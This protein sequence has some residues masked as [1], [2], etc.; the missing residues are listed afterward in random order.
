MR[1][2][3]FVF[4]KFGNK[5]QKS[6][7][8][9]ATGKT[10][11]ANFAF[12]N[13]LINVRFSSFGVCSLPSAICFFLFVFWYMPS[14]Y[15]KSYLKKIDP[16]VVVSDSVCQYSIN[17][18]NGGL[19]ASC[20]ICPANAS[21][22]IIWYDAALNPVATGSPFDP[23]KLKLVNSAIPGNYTFTAVCKCLPNASNDPNLISDGAQVTFKVIGLPVPKIL[24]NALPCS[25]EIAIYV[26]TDSSAN[27]YV[28]KYSWSLSGGGVLSQNNGSATVKW[29]SGGNSGPYTL[30]VREKN[31][32]GCESATDYIVYI[33]GVVLS[34]LPK[35]NISLNSNCQTDVYVQ[36]V[37][38]RIVNGAS[39]MQLQL[40]WA[41]NAPVL[42]SGIGKI[43]IDGISPQVG[44]YDYKSNTFVYTVTENCTGNSCSGNI[45]VADNTPPAVTAPNDFTVNCSDSLNLIMNTEKIKVVTDI[46]LLN[47]PYSLYITDCSAYKISYSDAYYD[48]SCLTPFT[49]FP[50][51]IILTRTSRPKTLPN[52]DIT[53]I[54]V[55][56]FMVRDI[57]ANVSTAQQIIYVRKALLRNVVLPTDIEIDYK[58]AINHISSGVPILVDSLNGQ[59]TNSYQLTAASGLN[60]IY[61]D[62]SI[63]RCGKSFTILRHWKILDGC[64]V[65]DPTASVDARFKNGSQII[66]VIDR[67]PPNT[68]AQF[69]QYYVFNG[70]LSV[71]DTT[72]NFVDT[73]Q[74]LNTN[75]VY[76][77]GLSSSCGASVRFT[78][79]C[80]KL[81]TLNAQPITFRVSD[82]RLQV[83]KGYPAVDSSTGETVAIFEGI[84]DA[85]GDYNITFYVADACGYA[86]AKKTFIIHVRD[87]VK[88]QVVCASNI[89]VSL[90]SNKMAIITSDQLNVGSTDNC[91]IQKILVRRISNCQNP[92][93]VEFKDNVSF[94]CCDV[95][96]TILVIMRVYDYFGN[97]ND[98]SVS[99]VVQDNLN[100]CPPVVSTLNG[101]IQ[102]ENGVAIEGV[103]V[104][105]VSNGI[106]LG[107][108]LTTSTGNF[109]INN[110]N[111]SQKVSTYATRNDDA[112][113]GVTTYDI[114]LISR[115]ILD[116][117]PLPTTYKM[118]AADVNKDGE[119][120]ALDM[121]LM[122]RLVLHIIPNFPNNTAWR[123]I[124][125]NYTFAHPTDPFSENFPEVIA[126]NIFKGTNIA[127]F[128]GVKIG[129]LNNSV[130]ANNDLNALVTRGVNSNF[131]LKITTPDKNLKAGETIDIVLHTDN[132][133][134][135]GF[136]FTL[137]TIKDLE[138]R[139]VSKAGYSSKDFDI[140]DTN[141]GLFENALTVSWN[142]KQ[143]NSATDIITVTVRAKNNMHLSEALSIGSNITPIEAFDV[144][145]KI[146]KVVL[147]ILKDNSTPN[148]A[149]NYFKLYQNA[150][151]PF[152]SETNIGFDLSDDTPIKL[153][154]T[155]A[156][157]QVIKVFEKKGVRGY[158]TINLNKSDIGTAGLYFYRLEAGMKSET[159]MTVID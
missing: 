157:G 132:L 47:S 55:R 22:S 92:T 68:T 13:S 3:S 8:K 79:R 115:H 75:N 143:T 151:N 25:N 110:L 27:A 89:K 96:E 41:Y 46:S 19:K 88:P 56:T 74:G 113:N 73:L 127:N 16:P 35:I 40:F 24:G 53:R 14:A 146:G 150:P 123:F 49:I 2:P 120:N 23:I 64:A 76:P 37:L 135:Q 48:I 69:T 122:R 126:T 153:T 66:K 30:T 105:T 103:S 5:V 158:N 125:K 109:T 81:S 1:L 141:F 21:P 93:D 107:T 147:A 131:E 39:Q 15:C 133:T 108:F 116:I 34:C 33:K 98:C 20:A 121:L 102:T 138:I 145:G 50:D 71:R 84:F 67:L 29:N 63:S 114:A 112:Q 7:I 140:S 85:Y 94:F 42:E 54:I 72:S 83:L 99:V 156:Q 111:V 4:T 136:Q 10:Q 155:N 134:A 44:A 17:S 62:D 101:S 95:N 128:V 26:C 65:Y 61:S 77:Q 52:P 100:L 36:D 18:F 58:D 80:P 90:T 148:T 31:I 149:H 104:N 6:R 60:V 139:A 38:A 82:S 159:L 9:N 144:D 117:Q 124:D 130:I 51:N 78:L 12:Y 86:T 129:D 45:V 11:N 97:F 32:S 152:D 119:V 118:I 28:N 142:G 43:T 70:E 91:A 59:R 106:N 137:N 57:Y 154:I 87:N